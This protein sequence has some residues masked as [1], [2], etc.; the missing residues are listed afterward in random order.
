M[1]QGF[2]K[3]K[4]QTSMTWGTWY[5]FKLYQTESGDDGHDARSRSLPSAASLSHM[6]VVFEDVA[7][8]TDM[9]YNIRV[10]YDKAGND[11]VVTG[12][13]NLKPKNGRNFDSDDENVKLQCIDFGARYFFTAPSTQHKTGQIYL[14]VYPFLASGSDS[15]ATANSVKLRTARLHWRDDDGS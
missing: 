6:D 5:R 8:G 1:A 3:N 10:T 11:P 2:I 13:N 14:F 15:D 4:D 9:Q 12:L 7:S